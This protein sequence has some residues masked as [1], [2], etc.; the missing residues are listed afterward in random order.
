MSCDMVS[1]APLQARPKPVGI[2]PGP[3][4]KHLGEPLI[5]ISV[6]LGSFCLLYATDHSSRQQAAASRV[7]D[8][9]FARTELDPWYPRPEGPNAASLYVRAF[10]DYKSTADGFDQKLDPVWRIDPHQSLPAPLVES[11][12]A[13]VREHADAIALLEQATCMDRC[14]FEPVVINQDQQYLSAHHQNMNR[15][16]QLLTLS[17]VLE[18]DE[19][20]TA[21]A[22][23][24][25]AQIMRIA[26]VLQR[27][28]SLPALYLSYRIRSC[29]CELA[30]RLVLSGWLTNQDLV[31]LVEALTIEDCLIPDWYFSLALESPNTPTVYRGAKTCAAKTS[32]IS[33]GA[34]VELYRR[35]EGRFPDRM[36]DLVPRYLPQSPTD[37]FD[38]QCLR[39]RVQDDRATIY[40]VGQDAS[41]DGGRRPDG[42]IQDANSDH[43]DITFVL[44]G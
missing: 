3:W 13:C 8:C 36:N 17:A 37:P 42:G 39:Y 11:L 19:G 23:E 14:R 43:T 38:Y 28:P 44:G 15:A 10:A 16:V 18:L 41:D 6:V 40:S 7:L 4:R 35:A 34:L 31:S 25:V 26:R 24:R 9:S 29:A 12:R 1:L 27:E 20:G 21:I 32:V 5:L 22:V 2:L 30:E 33:V